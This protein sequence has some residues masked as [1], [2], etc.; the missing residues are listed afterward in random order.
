M[1]IRPTIQFSGIQGVFWGSFASL[2]AF[3]SVYL[4]AKGFTNSQVGYVMAAGSGLSAVLQPM[5]G[6]FVDRSPKLILHKTIL[7]LSLVMIVLS[8]LLLGASNVFWAVALIYGLL[9]TFLQM[10]TPLTY[11]LGMFFMSRGVPINFGICRGIGSVTYAVVAAVLGVLVERMNEDMVVVSVIV[12]YVLFIVVITT[13][14]FPGISEEKR[15]TEVQSKE[16]GGI[17]A[18]I[19][20]NRGFC[21]VLFGNIFVFISH[22]IL[23]NYLFQIVSYHGFGSKEMGFA[24]SLAAMCELPTLFCLSFFLKKFSEVTLFR[25]AAIFIFLKN[26][27]LCFATT[28]PVIYFAMSMQL[29]GYG[30]FAGI[31]VIY[32][33]EMVDVTNRTRGQ[34]LMT[35]TVTIGTVFGSLLGGNFI[36]RLGVPWTL[37]ISAG[38]AL[39][40][41]VVVC[42][43]AGKNRR[44]KEL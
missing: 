35:M 39:F 11:A 13:F 30:L 42:G 10:I 31:S 25:V 27:V 19:R 34:A 6:G 38:M 41:M 1:K 33:N 9:V 12:L 22:N 5:L 40:G 20:E 17:A 26:L 28:L 21:M 44:N 16:Q 36:D 15:A 37:W 29:L 2:F 3:S 7:V 32:V 18:F 8:G 23:N 43:F 14:H 24:S 4:L